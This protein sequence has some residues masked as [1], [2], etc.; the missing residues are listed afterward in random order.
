MAEV[1]TREAPSCDALHRIGEKLYFSSDHIYLVAFL[2]CSGKKIIGTTQAGGRTAFL[3]EKTPE[4]SADVAGFM[5]GAV[6]PARQFSF[7]LL[8]LKRTL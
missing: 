6:V 7:E 4:L 3:F 2:V 1:E 8:K 5:A